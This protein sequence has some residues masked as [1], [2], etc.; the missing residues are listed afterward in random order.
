MIKS[1]GPGQPG[2]WLRVCASCEWLFLDKKDSKGC[3][4]CHFGHYGAFWTY[5]SKFIAIWYWI[6]QIP[7]RRRNRN[8]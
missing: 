2:E 5:N 8:D 7:Y 1:K 4:K 6:T 3:P